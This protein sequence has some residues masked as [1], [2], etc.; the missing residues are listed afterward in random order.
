MPIA[1]VDAAL[2]VIQLGNRHPNS[3]TPLHLDS[4]EGGRHSVSKNT[5]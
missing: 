5:H 1:T 4:I 2:D 3:R